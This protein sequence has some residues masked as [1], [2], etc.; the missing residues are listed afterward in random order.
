MTGKRGPYAKTEARR[1]AILEAALN[2]FADSGYQ[3]GSLRDVAERVGVTEAALTYYFP[4]KRTL[5]TSVL[6]LRDDLAFEVSPLDVSDPVE[7]LR[8]LVRLARHNATMPGIIALHAKTSSEAVSPSHPAH[9]YYI[10]RYA[11]IVARLTEIFE[12]CATRGLLKKHVQPARAARATVALMDGLQIQW[13][14]DPN[15]TDMADELDTH[16]R[17]LIRREASWDKPG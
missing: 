8:G 1:T 7:A 11:F 6:E 14:I 5:L 16:V 10:K 9:D 2:V 3:G 17:S 4:N 12:A 13:L 15:S